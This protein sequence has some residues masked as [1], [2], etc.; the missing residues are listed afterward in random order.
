MT[1]EINVAYSITAFQRSFNSQQ[2][3]KMVV[4]AFTCSASKVLGA[5]RKEIIYLD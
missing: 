2:A 3:D 5:E 1:G 4:D